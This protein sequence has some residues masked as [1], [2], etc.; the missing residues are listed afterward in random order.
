MAVT[1]TVT[2]EDIDQGIR[3]S[4]YSCPIA[5][6]AERALKWRVMVYT[7][8]I[9]VGDSGCDYKLPESAQEFISRFDT[10]KPVKP[11]SFEVG[12]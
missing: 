1:I 11:F 12:T 7:D 3:E 8:T 4:Y 6:A 10:G 5:R 9:L 2:Q